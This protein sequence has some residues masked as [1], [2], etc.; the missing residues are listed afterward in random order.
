VSHAEPIVDE[1]GPGESR[2]SRE[3]ERDE[4]GSPI[5]TT[6]PGVDVEIVPVL[7]EE[8]SVTKEAVET[9]RVRLSVVTHTR[10]ELVDELLTDETAEIE[11]VAIGKPVDSIPEVRQEGD[12]TIVPVVEEEIVV[13]RRLML[14]EE[15]RIRR[16]RTTRRH[17]ERVILHRQEAAISRTVAG[18]S[19]VDAPGGTAGI[20]STEKP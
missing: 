8:L 16:V 10:D 6:S 13:Q 20:G 11:H 19:A 17:Q 14:K 9:G 15:I 5:V 3:A 2:P 7:A 4:A 18:A 12:I 1:K